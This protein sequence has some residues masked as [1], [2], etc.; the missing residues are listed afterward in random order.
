[1]MPSPDEP[2]WT[3]EFGHEHEVVPDGIVYFVVAEPWRVRET[4]A[5]RETIEV[6]RLKLETRRVLE[7]HPRFQVVQVRRRVP[8]EVLEFAK[9]S[10][11]EMREQIHKELMAEVSVGIYRQRARPVAD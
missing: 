11:E 5:V 8:R 7:P 2:L 9:F 3:Y 1:M 4:I 6:G 10:L